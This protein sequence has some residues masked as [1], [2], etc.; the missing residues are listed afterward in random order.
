MTTK[1]KRYEKST[2]LKPLTYEPDIPA[3]LAYILSDTN[4]GRVNLAKVTGISESQ[5]CKV[6]ACERIAKGITQGIKLYLLYMQYT[7]RELP[8]VGEYHEILN[9]F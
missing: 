9:K 7:E 8:I 3:M 4:C 1:R 5:I 6:L 2:E